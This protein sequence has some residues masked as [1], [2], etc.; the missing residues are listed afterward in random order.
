M[1]GLGLQ[2]TPEHFRAH[3]NAEGRLHLGQSRIRVAM[4]RGQIANQGALVMDF[5]GPLP[6]QCGGDRVYL[7]QMGR[8]GALPLCP[9]GVRGAAAPINQALPA[10][11][12]GEE[13][14][15]GVVF[16]AGQL[17]LPIPVGAPGGPTA[18]PRQH[19]LQV[20][21]DILAGNPQLPD[22]LTNLLPGLCGQLA[23]P[24][25][26]LRRLHQHGDAVIRAHGVAP[27]RVERR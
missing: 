8:P 21:A 24:C 19:G 26:Q 16:L 18:D 27:L 22:D 3:I 2:V 13:M 10:E 23:G 25:R 7:A 17:R 6:D 12:D 4:M 11:P 5:L 20:V 15:Q 1:R 9:R 14:D